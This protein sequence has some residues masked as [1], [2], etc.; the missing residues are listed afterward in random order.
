[1][2]L[3]IPDHR[4]SISFINNMGV[5][6][7]QLPLLDLALA[8]QVM[9]E[10]ENSLGEVS[11]KQQIEAARTVMN[12][13]LKDNDT[14]EFSV[15][16]VKRLVGVMITF[17][18][19]MM[20]KRVLLIGKDSQVDKKTLSLRGGDRRDKQESSD[21]TVSE[22]DECDSYL[23][24][25]RALQSD[26]SRLSTINAGELDDCEGLVRSSSV[27]DAS[28]P[29]DWSVEHVVERALV[30][31]NPCSGIYWLNARCRPH[32]AGETMR[33]IA[34]QIAY[35][36]FTSSSLD[37]F[38]VGIHLLRNSGQHVETVLESIYLNSSIGFVRDRIACHLAHRGFQPN[39]NLKKFE[40]LY[41][42][43]CYVTEI[44]RCWTDRLGSRRNGASGQ[45][46]IMSSS[47]LRAPPAVDCGNIADF[48]IRKELHTSGLIGSISLDESTSVL[49]CNP[50]MDTKA[51]DLA[52]HTVRITQRGY[53]FTTVA[54]IEQMTNEQIVNILIEGGC[55]SAKSADM[56]RY[57][58][59]NKDFENA[60]RL[61][62]QGATA[63]TKDGNGSFIDRIL[64]ESRLLSLLTSDPSSI[65]QLSPSA[66]ATVRQLLSPTSTCQP[67]FDFHVRMLQWLMVDN[68]LPQLLLLYLRRYSLGT[69]VEA[70]DAL[71]AA[72]GSSVP[73]EMLMYG[74]LGNDM[75]SRV[76]RLTS[77]DKQEDPLTILALWMVDGQTPTGSR[78]GTLVNEFQLLKPFLDAPV[79]VQSEPVASD[80]FSLSTFKRDVT[81][82]TLLKDVFPD[83]DFSRIVDPVPIPEPPSMS[84]VEYLLSQGRASTAFCEA[85]G[86]S[87]SCSS[88]LQTC[89]RRVA[90]Y[91]LFD[92]GVVASCVSFLDLFGESTETL[93]VDVQSART[94]LSFQPDRTLASII[95]VFL[96][97][98]S[99]NNNQLLTGLKLLEESAWAK[100]PP[101]AGAD[102]SAPTSAGFESPWHLV[103]LFCRVHNLP[104]SLTLLHELARNGDWVMFL[105]ESDL[106][107][108]PIETV[109]DVIAFYFDENP[110]RSH[111]NILVG[112]SQDPAISSGTITSLGDNRCPGL[113]QVLNNNSDAWLLAQGP[114]PCLIVK[115]RMNA[116]FEEKLDNYVFFKKCFNLFKF[117]LAKVYYA[118][119]GP[120]DRQLVHGLKLNGLLGEER[121]RIV[122]G[123][124]AVEAAVLEDAAV[125]NH[126]PVPD[127]SSDDDAPDSVLQLEKRLEQWKAVLQS[128]D[129]GSVAG[130]IDH[131]DLVA[132]AVAVLEDTF[133]PGDSWDDWEY[134]DLLSVVDMDL[135]ESFAACADA[136]AVLI[137]QD[138]PLKEHMYRIAFYALSAA[139][140]TEERLVR[141]ADSSNISAI[142]ALVVLGSDSVTCS[143]AST[144]TNACIPIADQLLADTLSRS[145]EL[146]QALGAVL[147][148]SQVYKQGGLLQKHLDANALA[149]AIARRIQLE[150]F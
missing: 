97:F 134:Y 92:D 77:T 27:H 59:R 19:A 48:K 4:C 30:T 93:R 136:K 130:I 56:L 150:A 127:G 114:D 139:F 13:L 122:C 74:R 96:N 104:R 120:E 90:F 43:N 1:M 124:T 35:L 16:F 142:R 10:V 84:H 111:L 102:G 83:L 109:R 40:Q 24:S 47:V 145:D 91:N 32:V 112:R 69:S 22:L 79:P 67:P 29:I 54:W 143:S 105:H 14:L 107:Q 115:E 132:P 33:S 26:L 70:V 116:L 147:T 140:V 75:L 15:G 28:F 55:N 38:F 3:C 60:E 71:V 58:V 113:E 36:F 110:L 87:S 37:S 137:Q 121:D 7:C 94:I 129:Y 82:A 12:F 119:L 49:K 148:V 17:I 61:I 21:A 23:R 103:A 86:L 63:T 34:R 6:E 126:D 76:A 62:L 101:T 78:A 52:A 72:V 123:G 51:V 44:N 31:S 106:Q 53:L 117:S 108:C 68:H 57:Y 81:I 11:D 131:C 5:G 42:N 50:C 98:E 18:N 128:R 25:L 9:H 2:L 89:A 20:K 138:D 100:E 149:T 133:S 41:A 146:P 80:A 39:V 144:F 118:E 141:F 45:G 8:H 65:S 99:G 64:T 135:L 125:A 88:V 73:L 85:V 95:S 46:R 66:A